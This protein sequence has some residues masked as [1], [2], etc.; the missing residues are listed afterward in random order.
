MQRVEINNMKK[1]KKGITIL[2]S[3][4]LSIDKGEICALIGPNGVGKTTLIKCLLGLVHPDNGTT[5]IN[6]KILTDDTRSEILFQI[7]AV[8]Q[9]P[10]SISQLTINQLFTE[11]FH[12]LNLQRPESWQNFLQKVELNISTETQIGKLSLGMKQRL[13]LALALSHK[14]NI[15]VL[16]EPFNGLDVDG[17]MLIKNT[18]K[19][20]ISE[21][22]SVLIASH[23][24]SELEDLATSI[25]FMLNGVTFDKKYVNEIKKEYDGGLHQYYQ[26]LKKGHQQ[27]ER[28]F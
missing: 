4:N 15:I 17:I 5:Q 12:Y 20:L 13:L 9:Y 7:G 10:T 28:I 21:N 14:P 23:S 1:S 3:V 19:L 25:V 18:L 22:I 11:H 27:N 26:Y 24:L 8:L 2:Q 16:D 6:G